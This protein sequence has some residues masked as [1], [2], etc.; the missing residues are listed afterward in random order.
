M[1]Y[2]ALGQV[3]K[4][5][6]TPA[7]GSTESVRD[8]LK[9]YGQLHHIATDKAI[10]TGYTAQFKEIFDKAGMNLNDLT[11]KVLLEGHAGRHSP[12][13]H[14]HVLERLQDTTRGLSGSNYEK[15][16][17]SELDA[18]KQ[19]LLKNPDIVKGNGINK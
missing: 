19:E 5:T 10:K 13:Y 6:D 9:R 14:D 12:V 15:A 3:V 17:R 1:D 7:A 8:T 2:D 18:L 16:L 11:N 4:T